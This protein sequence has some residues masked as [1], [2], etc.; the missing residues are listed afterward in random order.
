MDVV[1]VSKRLS[2]VLRH[3]PDSVGLRLDQQGWVAVEDLLA[4][5]AAHG[6]RLSRADLDSVVASNDKQ[7]FAYDASGTRIRANQGHSVAVELGYRPEPP[8]AELFHGTTRRA[9]DAILTEG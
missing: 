5:L 6:L 2:Y 1:R 8:P 4:A 7:R 9:L 3:S